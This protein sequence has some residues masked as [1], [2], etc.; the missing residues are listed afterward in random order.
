MADG[1]DTVAA[2]LVG[3]KTF[4]VDK[5]VAKVPKVGKYS[6]L[7]LPALAAAA[8]LAGSQLKDLNVRAR[9][10]HNALTATLTQFKLDLEQGVKDKLL[11]RSL[12]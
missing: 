1:A 7:V 4:G 5:V 9:K 8:K 2:V 10:N 11:I 6:K 12:K 3:A